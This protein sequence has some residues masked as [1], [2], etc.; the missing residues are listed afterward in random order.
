MFISHK[1]QRERINLNQ[2]VTFFPHTRAPSYLICFVTTGSKDDTL[3]W[4]FS[5]PEERDAVLLSLED[6]TFVQLLNPNQ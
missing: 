4:H 2:V 1:S 6:I 3:D 5:S